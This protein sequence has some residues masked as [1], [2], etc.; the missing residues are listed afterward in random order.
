MSGSGKGI[1]TNLHI[2]VLKPG[3]YIAA[4]VNYV[5]KP[6]QG[7]MC[8]YFEFQIEDHKL[9]IKS[10]LIQEEKADIISKFKLLVGIPENQTDCFVCNNKVIKINIE[11]VPTE[12]GTRINV[13]D[14]AG[15]ADFTTAEENRAEHIYPRLVMIIDDQ[16]EVGKLLGKYIESL[17]Y[18]A[19]VYQNVDTALAKFNPEHYLFIITDIMM[20]GKNGFDLVRQV[21]SKY[22]DTT[23]A[24]ISGYFDRE[25]QNMQRVFGIRKIYKK[26]VFLNAIKEMIAE[27]EGKFRKQLI[28][29]SETSNP[30]YFLFCHLKTRDALVESQMMKSLWFLFHGM[31]WR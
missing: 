12:R 8:S 2:P 24:L 26:P 16:V 10:V 25:M 31:F 28:E 17:G 30:F 18:I 9:K 11:P 6:I 22:P 15:V 3:W 7:K 13:L 20:P 4:L 14:F 5:E 21:K 29:Q 1:I 27:A 19:D 23:L